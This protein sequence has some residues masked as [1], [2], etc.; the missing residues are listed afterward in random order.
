MTMYKQFLTTYNVRVHIEGKKAQ[1]LFISAHKGRLV[2][3][4]SFVLPT[5]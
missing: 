3:E 5:V 1:S 2:S 4:S